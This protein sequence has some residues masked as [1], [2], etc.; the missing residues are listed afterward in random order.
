LSKGYLK[1]FFMSKKA[2]TLVEMVIAL[3]ITAVLASTALMTLNFADGRDLDT[4]SRSLVS[5]LI[6]AREMAVSNHTN[7]TV[8]FDNT[9][10]TYS[11]YKGSV[12]PANLTR[13]RKFSIELVNVTNWTSSQITNFTF[14][15]PKGNV[16]TAAVINLRQTGRSRRVNISDTT[17]FVRMEQ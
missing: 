17:G 11:F 1:N 8:V 7:Y 12:T 10:D 2:L 4:Q 5:D 16:S 3:A 15:F 13:K 9:N 14:R 6:W